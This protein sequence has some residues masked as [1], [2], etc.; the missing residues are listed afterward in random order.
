[1]K[2]GPR[3]FVSWFCYGTGWENRSVDGGFAVKDGFLSNGF[4]G[5]LRSATRHPE[6]AP[7]RA[8]KLFKIATSAVIHGA[9]PSGIAANGNE[10][11]KI[12][13]AEATRS[14]AGSR[15]YRAFYV[16]SMGFP[17]G[18]KRVEQTQQ[19][20]GCMHA[21]GLLRRTST[22]WCSRQPRATLATTTVRPK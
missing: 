3:S 20:V 17:E 5:T 7:V 2:L 18:A 12:L 1:M 16:G 13:L 8:P 10:M 6:Y 4:H 15:D 21:A 9:C 19:V 22:T 11:E 14:K